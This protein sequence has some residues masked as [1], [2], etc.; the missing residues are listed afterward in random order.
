MTGLSVT[1]GSSYS[2]L[3]IAYFY[4]FLMIL[5]WTLSYSLSSVELSSAITLSVLTSSVE[6]TYDKFFS[7]MIPFDFLLSKSQMGGIGICC[8]PV[9]LVP[10]GLTW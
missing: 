3:S 5:L 2:V 1:K 9:I 4:L 10:I 6:H 7:T 8:V